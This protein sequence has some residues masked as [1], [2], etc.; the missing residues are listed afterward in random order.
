MIYVEFPITIHFVVSS[1]STTYLRQCIKSYQGLSSGISS[2]KFCV[3]ALDKK[4][5]HRVRRLPEVTHSEWVGDLR[6]SMGH[7]LGLERAIRNFD[8]ENFNIVSDV[9]VMMLRRNWDLELKQLH[10]AHGIDI[11]G[12]QHEKIGGFISGNSK[13]QQYKSLP[14]TTWFA[15]KKGIHLPEMD[16]KPDKQNPLDIDTVEL[17]KIFNLPVGFSL[18][19]DT[20]W[21][22]PTYFADQSITTAVLDLIKPT[23]SASVV[24][25]GESPYHDEFHLQ[26][27]PFLAHQRGSMN[28]VYR[29]DKLSAGFYFACDDYLNFPTWSIQPSFLDHLIYFRKRIFRAVKKLAKLLK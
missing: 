7:A 16:L 18:F 9:D 24:L 10:E 29:I 11:V 25:Q 12:T 1:N 22:L 23:D 2:L 15:V 3:Y 28:H 19:K 17:S 4:T 20:G 26:G 13:L 27:K 6:G 14:S 21:R 5:L 8:P